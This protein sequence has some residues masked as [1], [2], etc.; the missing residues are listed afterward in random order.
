MGGGGATLNTSTPTDNRAAAE[1]QR[2]RR[3]QAPATEAVPWE[4]VSDMEPLSETVRR[5]DPTADGLDIL[6]FRSS[7]RSVVDWVDVDEDA[8]AKR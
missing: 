1:A 7:P 2:N 3:I 8:R 5:T 4:R 6:N